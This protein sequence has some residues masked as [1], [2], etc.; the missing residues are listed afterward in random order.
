MRWLQSKLL[1]KIFSSAKLAVPGLILLAAIISVGTL[2]ESRY[3]AEYAKM[4][5]YDTWWFIG[6]LGVLGLTV[7]L[8]TLSRWP[9]Q[10]RHV[11][12]LI[13]HLGIIIILAGSVITKIWGIDGQLAVVEGEIGDQVLINE[14][15]FEYSG[16]RQF[17]KVLV[18][19]GPNKLNEQ[20]LSYLNKQLPAQ[21]RVTEYLP[22]VQSDESEIPQL[23]T[24]HTLVFRIQSNF[25]DQKAWLNSE[26]R[27]Q[28]QMGPALIRMVNKASKGNSQN[29]TVRPPAKSNA[30][31]IVFDQKSEADLF[32]A[33]INEAKKGFVVKGVTVKIKK[34]FKFASVNAN[35]ITEGTGGTPNPAVE[36]EF[37]KNGKT[38][39]DVLFAKFPGFSLLNNDDLGMRARY[40]VQGE[41]EA[42][43]EPTQDNSAKNI[44]EFIVSEGKVERIHLMKDGRTVLDEPLKLDTPVQTPWMGMKITLL[45]S[46]NS[47]NNPES[48]DM[49]A[50]EPTPKVDFLPP[51]A[52]KVQISTQDS[53]WLTEGQVKSVTV[54][55][56]V[57]QVYYGANTIRLPFQL[58]LNKFYKIDYPG[59]DTP[60]EFASDVAVNGSDR[61]VKISMNEP[62][63][64]AGYTLYQSS[65]DLRPGQPAVS[66]FSV[67][68]DPGRW[69]KYLGS[70]ILA[71]GIITFTVMRSR[72]ARKAAVKGTL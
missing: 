30:Q 49:I 63:K 2:V 41:V 70:L 55:E 23:N 6:L 8:S 43:E 66:I 61:V 14:K 64:E 35:K 50:I 37:V 54:G 60:M 56:E 57:Y 12:F 62:L 13:T 39:R 68:R 25:F 16:P 40:E 52:I 22:F 67:N 36:I 19:R 72:L 7:F 48:K 26:E 44:V 51:S 17:N 47:A 65:Y 24:G 20:Q 15:V 34:F 4:L 28:I 38:Y 33:N 5:V 42:S 32:K 27:S 71:I 10:K 31:I 45:Q 18:R 3:N 59:T 9:W 29:S 53:F 69:I 46:G 21:F 11:G 1:F 58:K